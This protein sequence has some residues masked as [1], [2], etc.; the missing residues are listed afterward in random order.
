M[1]SLAS[2][3]KATDPELVN[4]FLRDDGIEWHVPCLDGHRPDLLKGMRDADQ[5]RAGGAGSG[6]GAVV[7]T[8]SL[9]ETLAGCLLYTSDAAD[10]S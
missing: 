10:E 1:W 9:A 8:A 4:A 7:E 2:S 3:R 6:D 5:Q